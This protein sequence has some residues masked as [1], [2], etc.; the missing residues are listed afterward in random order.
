VDTYKAVH[1]VCMLACAIHQ[2]TLSVHLE[3]EGL[4]INLMENLGVEGSELVKAGFRISEGSGSE[5][6]TGKLQ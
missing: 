5:I 1:T 6:R 3:E 4:L 2:E